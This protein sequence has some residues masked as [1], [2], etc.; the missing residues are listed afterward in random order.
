ML[1]RL[2]SR[3]KM[4][5]E[6]AREMKLAPST[7]VEHLKEL[8]DSGLV[9][10]QET[11]H[12]W[13]YYELTDKGTDLFQPR[14]PFQ[15]ILMLAFG[16]LIAGLSFWNY[17]SITSSFAATNIFEETRPLGIT[18][19]EGTGITNITASRQPPTG[20]V[21]PNLMDNEILII[22]IIIGIVLA[23]YAAYSI[24]KIRKK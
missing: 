22:L 21:Y 16:I 17:I 3:R 11:Q 20:C 6:L 13:I 1:K 24:Y 18:V 15:F 12:K 23:A 10:K 14:I 5:A 9:K 7:V 2:S 8:E 4:P 19:A